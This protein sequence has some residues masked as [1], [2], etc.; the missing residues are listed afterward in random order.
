MAE[1]RKARATR[2][3]KVYE[4][5]K[6]EYPEAAIRL[7][8]SSPFELLVATILAAQCTD[9]KVNEVTAD[10]FEEA[11]TPGDFAEMPLRTLQSRIRPTGFYRN[12]AKSIKAMS[13]RLIAEHGG[14]VPEAMEDLVDLPGVARKTANVVRDGAF[15]KPAIITDTHVIRLSG[16]LGLSGHK[17][18]VKIEFDLRALLHHNSWGKFSHTLLFHGRAVCTAR[19]PKCDACVVSD[20]CPWAFDFPHF[21]GKKGD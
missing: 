1:T 6:K 19:K 11:N 5:L 16:R 20:L 15:G 14:R 18:P 8:F 13:E 21:E 9:D 2:A 10:L 17:D 4:R 3:K 7:R 12:K